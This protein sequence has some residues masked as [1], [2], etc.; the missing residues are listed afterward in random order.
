M[1]EHPVSSGVVGPIME[2]FALGSVFWYI[3]KGTE[4]YADLEGS[5]RVNRLI[6]G[7]FP[8]TDPQNPVDNVI[9]SY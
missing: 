2:Q 4:V 8:L 9:H 3:T 5:E 1:F 7:R 6:D